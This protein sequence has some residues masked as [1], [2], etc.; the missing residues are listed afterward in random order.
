MGLEFGEEAGFGFNNGS[1]HGFIEALY[2]ACVRGL[3]FTKG[4]F[5]GLT[6]FHVGFA[7]FN[8]TSLKALSRTLQGVW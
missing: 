1:I 4:L 3:G 5:T 6:R 2:K 8:T 7:G